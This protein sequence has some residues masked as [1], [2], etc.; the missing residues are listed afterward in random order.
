MVSKGVWTSHTGWS[1]GPVYPNFR[2][3]KFFYYC[4]P[5]F[6]PYISSRNFLRFIAVKFGVRCMYQEFYV[7]L[8]FAGRCCMT[9]VKD[10]LCKILVPICTHFDSSF[11]SAAV[12]GLLIS[13]AGDNNT[14]PGKTARFKFQ[15]HALSEEVS[16]RDV[17]CYW[18]GVCAVAFVCVSPA[19]YSCV[20]FINTLFVVIIIIIIIMHICV[21]V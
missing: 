18:D 1:K 11:F 6:R 3:W 8:N 19:S 9:N 4:N 2:S 5:F 10:S 20:R 13:W 16:D 7:E 17:C 21:I 12:K 14:P 15:G